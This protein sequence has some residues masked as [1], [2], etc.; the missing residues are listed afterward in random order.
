MRAHRANNR[1]A[2]EIARHWRLE[3]VHL[4]AF[5]TTLKGKELESVPKRMTRTPSITFMFII[6]GYSS[7]LFPL[8]LNI[9]LSKLNFSF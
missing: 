9:F 8:Y 1:R 5:G 6:A 4:L 3:I 7:I 2:F